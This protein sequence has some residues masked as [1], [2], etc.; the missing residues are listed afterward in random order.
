MKHPIPLS[1]FVW[2]TLTIGV[3]LG[4]NMKSHAQKKTYQLVDRK[5]RE[6]VVNFEYFGWPLPAYTL[7]GLKNPFERQLVSY[8]VG[9]EIPSGLSYLHLLVDIFVAFGIV[10]IVLK[11]KKI[12]ILLIGR[13]THPHA[14]PAQDLEGEK[15]GPREA[16][17]TEHHE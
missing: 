17:C 1:I 12:R 10:L 14:V 9:K 15:S 11:F 6:I 2:L 3:L 16:D 5:V 13:S 4:L 7:S 8:Y